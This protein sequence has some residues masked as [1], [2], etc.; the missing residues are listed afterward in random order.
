[1]LDLLEHLADKSLVV[2]G[3]RHG[4]VRYSMLE[5]I[6]EYAAEK[7][8]ASGEEAR[9]RALHRGWALRFAEHAAEGARGSEQAAWL[10]LIEAEHD[11]MRAA[12]RWSLSQEGDAEATLRLVNALWGFWT[13]RGHWSEA[14]AIFEEAV[15]RC[16][17][18]PT[19]LLA[20]AVNSAANFAAKQSD[21]QRARE[22]YE[23]SLALRRE[24]GDTYAAAGSL[25]NLSLLLQDMGD[26]ETAA[27]LAEECLRIYREIGSPRDL[28]MAVSHQAN[29]AVDQG[30]LDRATG[31]YEESLALFK[32]IGDTRGVGYTLSN[33]GE[34]ARRR[35]EYEQ[36]GAY[37]REGLALSD[38]LGF[39]E[40]TAWITLAL[41]DVATKRGDT[42]G[43]LRLCAEALAAYRDLG[44]RK[45]QA[46]A[47]DGFAR[48]LA[49]AG[50]ERLAVRLA[51]A[52]EALRGTLKAPLPPSPRRERDQWLAAMR[53]LLGDAACD[54]ALAEGAAIP[55]E[56]A[57]R[58]ALE[59]AAPPPAG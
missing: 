6:R 2:V 40:L 53:R 12:V 8:A 3:E 15:G 57:V 24:A 35:G 46:Y 32:S 11:N 37:L 49:A 36:A 51:G 18:G 4:R 41:G 47:L 21:F 58:V 9:T 52:A 42:A 59:S 20:T 16:G 39:T 34:A 55:P 10:A 54:E 25:Y 31:L 45:S 56:Q 30:D 43:G 28:A 50:R 23:R 38:D 29:V 44:D 14:R 5:T 26:F 48:A 33:M 7:L 17:R 13:I 27:A 1:V 19:S 22:L